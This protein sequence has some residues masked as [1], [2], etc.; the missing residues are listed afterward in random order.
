LAVG[1]SVAFSTVTTDGTTA[2]DQLF[3][4][5]PPSGM[6][7]GC[8]PGGGPGGNPGAGHRAPPTGSGSTGSSNSM[9]SMSSS[10]SLESP[11]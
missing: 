6:A 7:G 4:G 9:S 10:S 11:A 5:Y 1:D 2:I 8:G 3:A